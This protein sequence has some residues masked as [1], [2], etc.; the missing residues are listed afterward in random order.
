MIK[1][2]NENNY[3]KFLVHKQRVSILCLKIIHGIDYM[4]YSFVI[5]KNIQAEENITIKTTTNAK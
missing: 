1:I 4:K 2:D 5:K 3:Y